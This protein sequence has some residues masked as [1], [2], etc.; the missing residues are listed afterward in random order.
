[1]SRIVEWLLHALLNVPPPED[2]RHSSGSGTRR[3][4]RGERGAGPRRAASARGGSRAVARRGSA[5]RRSGRLQVRA[6]E[7]PYWVIRGWRRVGNTLEGAYRTSSGS[8]AGEIK[9]DRAG[10]ATFFIINPPKQVLTGAHRP[11]FRGRGGG[12][13]WVH[14][15][16]G[17]D[18]DGG[19]IAIEAIIA[20]AL[21][22]GR[23]KGGR[24]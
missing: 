15:S 24:R 8:F 18:V 7:R 9:L 14:L 19:I 1:M 12:R 3:V 2:E 23:R 5:C 22:A 13:F 21:G 4:G 11:C 16:R 6:D 20:D 17:W 10:R